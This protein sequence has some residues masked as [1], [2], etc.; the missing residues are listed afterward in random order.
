MHIP[1]FI[2]DLK[3]QEL[4]L[5][6]FSSSSVEKKNHHHVKLF[7]GKTCMGGGQKK[8]HSVVHDILNFENMQLYYLK[9]NT[10]LLFRKKNIK[11]DLSKND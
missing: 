4:S 7:Y 2:R 3:R 10:P 5:L 1:Q 9:Y 6:L 11:I 8:E